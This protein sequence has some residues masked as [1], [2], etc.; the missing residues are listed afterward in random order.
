VH[1]RT[2]NRAK[3]AGPRGEVRRGAQLWVA[4]VEVIEGLRR[5]SPTFTA[6]SPTMVGMD[7]LPIFPDPTDHQAFVRWVPLPWPL[8]GSGFSAV[9]LGCPG[10]G[11]AIFAEYEAA[12]EAA[13]THRESEGAWTP[14][15]EEPW[16]PRW[17]WGA[18]R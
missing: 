14:V 16:G 7:Q 6:W 5:A 8:Q 15:E 13:L 11:G 9:C 4:A 2:R 12:R 10:W 3:S 18:A 17:R 1:N